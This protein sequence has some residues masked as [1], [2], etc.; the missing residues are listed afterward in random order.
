MDAFEAVLF[1]EAVAAARCDTLGRGGAAGG[2]TGLAVSTGACGG[3]NAAGGTGGAAFDGTAAGAAGRVGS[4]H[5]KMQAT[6]ASAI[7]TRI[8][9][10]AALDRK[11]H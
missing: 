6:A 2:D 10:A 4:G 7:D 11:N 9:A 3:G 5:T 8:R 1:G